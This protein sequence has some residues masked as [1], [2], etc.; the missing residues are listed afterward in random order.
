MNASSV[1]PVAVGMKNQG[2]LNKAA[3]KGFTQQKL[4]VSP[5]KLSYGF[6]FSN[7]PL[8]S[9]P[10]LLKQM[11]QRQWDRPFTTNLILFFFRSLYSKF[12]VI[13]LFS[14]FSCSTVIGHRVQAI[15]TWGWVRAHQL[16]AWAP[17]VHQC[18]TH[19]RTI[20][21]PQRSSNSK[22]LAIWLM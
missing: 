9:A 4:V 18:R 3:P 5:T 17:E 16:A 21:T 1:L 14:M 19:S 2:Y 11:N 6:C 10:F 8:K 20:S 12:S 7:D 13:H 22:L 15:G